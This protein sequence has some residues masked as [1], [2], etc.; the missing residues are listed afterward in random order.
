MA[1]LLA[2]MIVWVCRAIMAQ[3]T[4]R[5]EQIQRAIRWGHL[6]IHRDRWRPAPEDQRAR[7]AV[8]SSPEESCLA[9]KQRTPDTAVLA[10]GL[11]CGRARQRPPCSSR[12]LLNARDMG[13]CQVRPPGLDFCPENTAKCLLRSA[14]CSRGRA[15]TKLGNFKAAC[16]KEKKHRAPPIEICRA[17]LGR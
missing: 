16:S 7:G 12:P 4:L 5:R 2:A 10:L 3:R 14:V 17:P 8:A 15:Q 11:A 6:A 9:C 13:H 1:D